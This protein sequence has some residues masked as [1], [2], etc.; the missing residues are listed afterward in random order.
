MG[1]SG[2][3]YRADSSSDSLAGAT[4]LSR[5]EETPAGMSPALLG[6]LPPGVAASDIIVRPGP[7]PPTP[8]PTAADAQATAAA[9]TRALAVYY[10]S[11]VAACGVA[12]LLVVVSVLWGQGRLSLVVFLTT[13]VSVVVLIG[14]AWWNARH[15]FRA[16][17]SRRDTDLALRAA[18]AVYHS[19]VETLPQ[20]IFR[21]DLAGRY[22]FG[23]GNFCRARGRPLQDVI[24]KS[25]YDFSPPDLAKRYREDDRKVVESGQTLDI[26]EEFIKPDGDRRY[27]HT[28]KTPVFGSDGRIV[29]VQG[30]HWDVTD[31]KLAEQELERKNRLLKR[32]VDAER[33][34]SLEQQRAHD[35]LKRTQSRLV[36]S[37]KL[38]GL[39]QLVAG[40]AHEINNP[41]AF[42]GNNVAVLQRD[43]KSV[44]EMLSRYQKADPVI[45]DHEP[46]LSAE[47]RELAAQIDLPY[48]LE[49]LY[50]LLTRSRDGLRRI[51]QIVNDLR[52]FARLDDADLHDADL[53]AGIEST[54]N[55]V[56]GKAKSRRVRIEKQLGALPPVS[57]YP[58]KVNQ[59]VM[60]L[61]TNAI[62]ASPE[63][64][65][66]TIRTSL[67]PAG[68]GDKLLQVKPGQTLESSVRI[69]VIDEGAGIAPAIRQRIFDPFFTT[70]PPGHGT[71]LGLSISYGIIQDHGGSIDVESS[72]G[73]G[74]TFVVMLPLKPVKG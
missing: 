36:Q 20:R 48:T 56:Q 41:L 17:A 3:D 21:K 54:V 1:D 74:A 19:L 64:S 11:P 47:L 63:G 71:G 5:L 35:E 4:P 8:E 72:P 29:G 23:N 2:T 33:Q 57:C 14:L 38:A 60:N 25:D 40:V 12:A 66:I 10:L 65:V 49:N 27:I 73:K 34:A 51:Q 55:I 9:K 16:N 18:E 15:L 62:D 69:E 42:V 44:V 52:H 28:I 30:I 61:L 45:A 58:A 70:K 7:Q 59:V 39:G 46:A 26:I 53:N 50:E 67:V 37:E 6:I 32:A 43:V 13:L 24:G 22:T 68:A 31:R